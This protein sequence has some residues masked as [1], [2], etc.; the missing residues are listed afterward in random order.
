MTLHAIEKSKAVM[1]REC[2][3][4]GWGKRVW[5][6]IECSGKLSLES[7]SWAL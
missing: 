2:V 7:V 1:S 4:E 3:C 5:F 6:I